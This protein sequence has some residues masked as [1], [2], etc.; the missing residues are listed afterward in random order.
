MSTTTTSFTHE[1]I[2]EEYREDFLPVGEGLFPSLPD[3]I[4]EHIWCAWLDDHE[5]QLL[6]ALVK[7][8][9]QEVNP[10][11][12][13]DIYVDEVVRH[14]RD[15]IIAALTPSEFRALQ[16]FVSLARRDTDSHIDFA[17][18][19]LEELFEL[20]AALAEAAPS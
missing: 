18:R 15:S 6:L 4:G 9:Q 10:Q 11:A 7:R 5:R 16:R 14:N 8:L 17:M 3:G 12:D 13:V 2:A 19:H 20:E 1:E